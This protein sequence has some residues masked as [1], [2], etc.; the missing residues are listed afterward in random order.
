MLREYVN[1]LL[2][3]EGDFGDIGM[4]NGPGGASFASSEQLYNIFVKPFSDVVKVTA[5]KT[6]EMSAR[7]QT[8]LKV[9]YEALAT[10][11]VPILKDNY[12]DIFEEES[13]EL[14]K[15]KSQYADVY[16]ATWESFQKADFLVAAFMYRP[17]LFLTAA[18]IKKSPKV[19]LNLASILSGGRLDSII[20][21]LTSKGSSKNEGLIRE[22]LDLKTL[23]GFFSNEKVMKAIRGSNLTQKISEDGKTVVRSSLKKVFSQASDALSATNLED[24]Q[25]KSGKRI[26]GLEKLKEIP[27]QERKLAEQNMLKGARAG[28]KAFFVEQLELRVK[29]ALD[30]GVP[31]EHPYI[32]DHKGVISKIK[33]L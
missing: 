15:I 9:A 31:G 25:R 8:S 7:A 33:S 13:R 30:A 6:K 26:P 10:T 22:G 1:E 17:D 28:I 20:S 21:R 14:D 11:L 4:D 23:V 32:K 24:L 19:A 29:Q 5:G 12:D 2:V 27:E 16:K 18:F 3:E